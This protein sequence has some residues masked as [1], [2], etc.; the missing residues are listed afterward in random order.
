M[1]P[2][3]IRA[4]GMVS[5]VGNSALECSASVRAGIARLA[6]TSIMSRGR[7]PLRMGLVAP[8]GLAPLPLVDT[9][10]RST[11]HRRVLR[12]AHAAIVEASDAAGGAPLPVSLVTSALDTQSELLL[13]DLAALLGERVDRA[14]SRHFATG[15]A[16]VFV[17]LLDAAHRIAAGEAGAVMVV[18]ADSLLDLRRLDALQQARRI[19]GDDVMDGFI[20]G[21]GAAALVVSA[22]GAGAMATIAAVGAG[23]DPFRHEGELPLTG[24]GLTRAAQ[25]ALGDT[26]TPVREVWCDLNGEAWTAREWGLAARRCHRWMAPEVE[27]RHPAE[28]FGDPGAAAGAMLLTLAAVGLYRGTS[29]GPSLVWSRTDAGLRGAAR[30]ERSG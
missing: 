9:A 13:D 5:S 26:P 8:D 28:F 3:S 22:A 11:R 10:A 17:A 23:D 18:G 1:I 29:R 16:G 6:T 2:L 25:A 15:A 4:V 30:L 21:E 19:L 24:D 27:V 12:L 20:P 7:S 14:S